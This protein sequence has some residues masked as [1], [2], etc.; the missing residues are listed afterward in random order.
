MSLSDRTFYKITPEIPVFDGE[1]RKP[2]F[3]TGATFLF[4]I[5][6]KRITLAD[7]LLVR[8]SLGVH[9]L[10]GLIRLTRN[11]V[12]FAL[13]IQVLGFLALFLRFYFEYDPAEALWQAGFHAVSGFNN[14][15]F[16]ILPQSQSISAVAG[17]HSQQLGR[18]EMGAVTV[19]GRSQFVPHG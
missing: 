16:V 6:G 14:A 9:Q 11:I 10:G 18:A 7:R 2:G 12:L 15:G 4:I 19:P 3:M 5:I 13:T 1:Y 8:E 17:G